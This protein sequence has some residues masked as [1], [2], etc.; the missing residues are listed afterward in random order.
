MKCLLCNE[1]IEPVA[2]LS[3]LIM[4]KQRRRSILVKI[5]KLNLKSL[6]RRDVQIVIK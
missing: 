1:W 6:G 2:Q 3:D 4:F 5:V